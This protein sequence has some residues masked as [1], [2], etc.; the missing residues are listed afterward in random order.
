M[1]TRAVT[2]PSNGKSVAPELLALAKQLGIDSRDARL[3]LLVEDMARHESLPAHWLSRYEPGQKRWQYTYT[4]TGESSPLHPCIDYYRGAVQLMNQYFG[5]HEDEDMYI[6]EVGQ[7]ACVA[8]LPEGWIEQE[9]DGAALVT[10]RDARSGVV[11]DEHPLDQ[12]F[13]ELRDRRRREL[14]RRRLAAIKAMQARAMQ[15]LHRRGSA[16]VSSGQLADA[17]EPLP[18]GPQNSSSSL[19]PGG[20]LL[21]WS[22]LLQLQQLTGSSTGGADGSAATAGPLQAPQP[23][24]SATFHPALPRE[25]DPDGDEVY[26]RASQAVRAIRATVDAAAAYTRLLPPDAAQALASLPKGRGRRVPCAVLRRVPYAHLPPTTAA[27]WL[28]QSSP[29]A[30]R[31]LGGGLSAQQVGGDLKASSGSDPYDDAPDELLYKWLA[32]ALRRLD[33]TA[34]AHA[35]LGLLAALPSGGLGG[36]A[37]GD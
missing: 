23:Q 2:L 26:E 17:L 32:A 22:A 15:Q 21:E 14:A 36:G 24:P 31:T 8:P 13:R 37:A 4:P 28:A 35:E 29:E 27:G 12:Y 34:A 6:R 30:L 16:S 11:L 19:L 5:I 20:A 25:E 9:E 33:E 10:Y 7:L 3:M 18:L 1:A